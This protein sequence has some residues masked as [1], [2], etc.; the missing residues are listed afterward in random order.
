MAALLEGPSH[1]Y[2]VNKRVRERLGGDAISAYKVIGRMEQTGLV[3]EI[4]V[5][6]GSGG[7]TA[8]VVYAV[9][10]AGARRHASWMRSPLPDLEA[11][12]ELTTRMRFARPEDLPS[13]LNVAEAALNDLHAR[14]AAAQAAQQRRREQR[15]R[16]LRNQRPTAREVA[17]LLAEQLLNDVLL[18][19]IKWLGRATVDLEQLLLDNAPKG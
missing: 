15:T 17:D 11:G 6:A 3:E 1:C 5:R 4:D 7:R 2:E 14:L 19:Q 9:T 12:T 16:P 13:L 18:L 8:Q 10:D